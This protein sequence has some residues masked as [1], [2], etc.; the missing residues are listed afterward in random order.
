MIINKNQTK[1]NTLH[2]ALSHNKIHTAVGPL[3]KVLNPALLQGG[4][5]HCLVESTVNRFG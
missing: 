2:D 1:N 5:V 4:I 3:S